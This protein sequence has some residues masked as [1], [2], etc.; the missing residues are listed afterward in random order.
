MDEPVFSEDKAPQ[1]FVEKNIVLQERFQ[2]PW[3]AKCIA[4]TTAAA[5]GTSVVKSVGDGGA[6][7]VFKD[8][9]RTVFN[10]VVLSR[11]SKIP[12]SVEVV[13][14]D[15]R[16]QFLRDLWTELA[17]QNPTA[18]VR[19]SLV[20][21]VPGSF[22]QWVV[23][24]K[25]SSNASAFSLVLFVGE[26]KLSL[27]AEGEVYLSRYLFGHH[28]VSRAGTVDGCSFLLEPRRLRL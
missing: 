3:I 12:W 14:T 7:T 25:C 18:D 15:S 6:R 27:L 16:E 5:V 4:T 22:F 10:S 1:R 24:R 23:G 2:P 11:T 17:L 28:T 19:Q 20:S 21:S 9:L 13:V 26:R 8:F